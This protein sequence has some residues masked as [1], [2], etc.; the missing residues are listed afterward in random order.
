[1]RKLLQF[2]APIFIIGCQST[3]TPPRQTK[4]AENFSH[5]VCNVKKQNVGNFSETIVFDKNYQ[6]ATIGNEMLVC[7]SDK[8]KKCK[9]K[10][11]T[12]TGYKFYSISVYI[13]QYPGYGFLDMAEISNKMLVNASY[14]ELE[15]NHQ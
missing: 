8:Y 6:T 7:T 15:C 5:I 3:A 4:Q 2:L 1:M 10:V 14:A 9:A 13:Y 11:N 12:P